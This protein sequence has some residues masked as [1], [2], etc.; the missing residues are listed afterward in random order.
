MLIDEYLRPLQ[1]AHRKLH[2]LVPLKPRLN[3]DDVGPPGYAHADD[4]ESYYDDC[5]GVDDG[6][7]RLNADE[8]HL[9]L[10]TI[11]TLLFDPMF[12]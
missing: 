6:A 1:R 11:L 4:Y 3:C 2:L 10:K 8:Y 9:I 7:I 12:R 5:D